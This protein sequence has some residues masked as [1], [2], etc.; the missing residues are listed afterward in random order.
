MALA[1]FF[2][3]DAVAISQVLQ[4]YETDAFV[5]QLEGVRVAIAFGEDAATSRDGRHLLDL[6]VRLAARLYPNLTISNTPA[7]EQIAGELTELAESINPNIETSSTNPPSAVLAIGADAPHVDAPTLYAG[8][9]GWVAHAGTAGPHGTS[10]LGNPFGA[11]FAA[12]LAAANLFRLLFLPHGAELLDEDVDFPPEA[13]AFPS[14]TTARLTAPL[15]LVGT[16]AVGNSAAWALGRTPLAGQIWLVDPELVDLS[17]LQRYVLCDRSDEGGVKAEIAAGTFQNTLQ[18]VPYLGTWASF[19][20]AK[21]YHWERV[22]VALDSARDRRAVQGSL[23]RWIANAWTQIG[24]LGVSS[25]SFQQP[26]ACL[27]CLY[28]PT[29]ESKSEDQIIAEGLR[30]PELQDRVRFLLDT[31]DGADRAICNAVAAG[32]EIQAERLEPYIG[33]PIRE[34]WEGGVC[35]GGIIPLGH[36]GSPPRDLQ[37][38]LAFQSALAGLLLASEAVRDVLTG[39][40]QRRTSVRRMDLLRPLGRPSPQPALRAGDGRC[41]CEDQDY[42]SVYRQKYEPGSSI[43]GLEAEQAPSRPPGVD[44]STGVR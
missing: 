41:I 2:H 18:P 36:A 43:A 6:C 33:K 35:G 40:A 15:V 22:L 17:N 26:N 37:V 20:E 16:G 28:L 13:A 30:I 14:L 21:G 34:L 3:R 5:E 24:D 4:G 31:G 7:A 10:D 19:L 1:E 23:P 8:C 27:S 12:C 44:V 42:V 29:A 11:G 39:G 32:F 38:P 25:H 9:D